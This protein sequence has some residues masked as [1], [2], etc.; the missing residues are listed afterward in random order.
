[1]WSGLPNQPSHVTYILVFDPPGS[2]DRRG[3]LLTLPAPMLPFVCG[4]NESAAL[5]LLAVSAC[6]VVVAPGT[7]F[8]GADGP[9]EFFAAPPPQA[10]S[11]NVRHALTR[12]TATDF[13]VEGRQIDS[14]EEHFFVR[15]SRQGTTL[16]RI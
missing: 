6:S 10:I 14:I 12:G 15:N 2:R 16:T 1:M 5:V 9:D 13:G 8:V 4:A 7:G 11:D 3:S